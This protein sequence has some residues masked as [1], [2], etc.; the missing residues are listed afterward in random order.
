LALVHTELDRRRS[1][2]ITRLVDESALEIS[3]FEFSLE[4]MRKGLIVSPVYGTSFRK[5]LRE[6][7]LTPIVDWKPWLSSQILLRRDVDGIRHALER[8]DGFLL[9]YNGLSSGYCRLLGPAAIDTS[10]SEQ[11]RRNRLLDFQLLLNLVLRRQVVIDT[12]ESLVDAFYLDKTQYRVRGAA[13]LAR[14]QCEAYRQVVEMREHFGGDG[15]LF[16]GLRYEFEPQWKKCHPP[17][18]PSDPRNILVRIDA[19]HVEHMKP[20]KDD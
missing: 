17:R 5:R 2:T 9:L 14:L 10:L 4:S 11:C 16:G 8:E 6:C 15:K 20:I 1:M 19:P 13:D 12:V 18:D 7:I 3:D